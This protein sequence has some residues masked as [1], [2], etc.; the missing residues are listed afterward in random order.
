MKNTT[1][2]FLRENV[3]TDNVLLIADK[4]Y[5]FKGNVKAIIK[6]YYFLN[7]WNDK[8]EIKKFKTLNSLNKYLN[9]FYPEI[10]FIDITGTSLDD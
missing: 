8:E 4:G 6:E 1:E 3:L 5:L 10:D 7:E 2:F 9:K